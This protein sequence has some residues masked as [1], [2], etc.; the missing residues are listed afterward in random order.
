MGTPFR[1]RTLILASLVAATAAAVIAACTDSYQL[2][3]TTGSSSGMT[4]SGHM[5]GGGGISFD[6]AGGSCDNVCSNDLKNVVDCK[7]QVVTPCT[8][9][10]GCA[11]GMCIDN[12]CT[13]AEQSKSS[14]GCD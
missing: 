13:A 2:P 5:G 8:V 12:P 6:G 4:S 1:R 9:D 11:N 14:Y 3:H 10:Q 7:G